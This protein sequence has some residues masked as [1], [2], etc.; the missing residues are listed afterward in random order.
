MTNSECGNY[1][2]GVWISMA[3]LSCATTA[4]LFGGSFGLL[5]GKQALFPFR[6]NFPLER[7]NSP[8]P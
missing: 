1:L 8:H 2:A 7:Q 3:I 5:N 6:Q 4:A